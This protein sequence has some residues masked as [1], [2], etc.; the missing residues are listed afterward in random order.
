MKEAFGAGA[1][2]SSESGHRQRGSMS[3]EGGGFFDSYDVYTSLGL[4]GCQPHYVPMGGM[5]TRGSRGRSP[6]TSS[7]LTRPWLSGSSCA[8]W[9]GGQRQ[10]EIGL[11]AELDLE[12]SRGGIRVSLMDESTQVARKKQPDSN[13]VPGI[14]NL[15]SGAFSF[16]AYI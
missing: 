15:L 13:L 9:G 4:G 12:R 6:K 14:Q 10:R 1:S 5:T 11:S 8:H 7:G 16:A 2:G 3:G